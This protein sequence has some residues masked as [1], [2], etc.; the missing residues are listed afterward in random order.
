MA[1]S[2]DDYATFCADAETMPDLSYPDVVYKLH[3]GGACT[4]TLNLDGDQGFDGVLS[5]RTVACETDEFCSNASAT[6][7]ENIAVHLDEGDYSVIVS[8][9]GTGTEAF[10]LTIGCATPACGD[11]VTNPFEECD[12]GNT[13]DGDGCAADCLFEASDPSLDTC[14][15]A[16][17][18]AGTV[19][20]TGELVHIPGQAPERT[21]I[22]ATESGESTCQ[23]ASVSPAPDHVY[24]VIPE[25]NGTLIA[26]LGLDFEGNPYCGTTE[27]TKLPYPAGC[28]DRAVHIREATCDV[29]EAEVACSD[30]TA[31]W[32]A[33]EAASAEV[34]AGTEYYV[35]V[36]GY[37]N[38]EFGQ[39]LYVLQL[40]LN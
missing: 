22:G 23:T 5:L 30:T 13:A 2:K 35:F 8:D 1:G 17:K 34:V 20:G 9:A 7:A 39:G 16:A 14:A 27:P 31:T 26:T 36:D 21:T 4:A 24:K 29:P 11:G 37:N 33:T 40:E 15:G 18:T 6:A 10:T 32:W 38:D 28:W 3:V 19:I 25:A 12:D